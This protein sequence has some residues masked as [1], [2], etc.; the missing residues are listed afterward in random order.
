MNSFF[1]IDDNDW[2]ELGGGIKR[3]IVGYTDDLMAVHLEFD[4]GAIG[5]P[6]AHD[7]HDQI[8]YVVKGSFEAEVDGEKC[9]L[10][11]GDAYIAAK[12]MVHGAVALEEGS[13]LLDLFSPHREDFLK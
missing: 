6:H 1:K 3:K 8:G 5:A 9:V 13:I 12:H 7:I 2:E 4:K 10:T 11:A